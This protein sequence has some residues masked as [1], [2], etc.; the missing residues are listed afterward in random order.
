MQLTSLHTAGVAT[1]TSPPG[2]GW[3]EHIVLG[4]VSEWGASMTMILPNTCLKDQEL[5]Q[6]GFSIPQEEINTPSS[7]ITKQ[8]MPTA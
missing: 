3:S 6:K 2:T 7:M 8:S 5:T 4:A 1:K